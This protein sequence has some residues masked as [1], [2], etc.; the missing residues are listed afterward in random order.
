MLGP[1]RTRKVAEP[2]ATAA[3]QVQTAQPAQNIA[4]PT[5]DSFSPEVRIVK[6]DNDDIAGWLQMAPELIFKPP[7]AA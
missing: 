6:F 4:I 7:K 1:D 3:S 2:Q 5:G